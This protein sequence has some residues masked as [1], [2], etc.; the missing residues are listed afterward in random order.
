MQDSGL[1]V[2]AE[3]HRES[4]LLDQGLQFSPQLQGQ[5]GTEPGSED[6]TFDRPQRPPPP[7]SV[8]VVKYLPGGPDT[9]DEYPAAFLEFTGTEPWRPGGPETELSVE[10]RVRAG[11]SERRLSPSTSGP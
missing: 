1:N 11:L 5:D 8:A 6:T 7:P 4:G 10:T 3:P 9:F 2:P